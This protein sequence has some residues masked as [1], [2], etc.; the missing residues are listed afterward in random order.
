MIEEGLRQ[1][2]AG[3]NLVIWSKLA[4]WDAKNLSLVASK[5]SNFESRAGH[6]EVHGQFGRLICWIAFGAGAEYLI[7]GVCLLNGCDL[8]KTS[9]C[10]RPSQP[11]EDIDNWVRLVNNNDPSMLES[12][13][14]FGTLAKLR[15]VTRSRL[16]QSIVTR[17]L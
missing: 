5:E 4:F 2:E 3:V 16:G 14:Y 12:D 10:T 11:G 8:N 7:K 13:I 17:K 15:P 6:K 1:I 9:K